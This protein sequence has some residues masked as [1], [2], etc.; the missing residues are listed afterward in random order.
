VGN[1]DEWRRRFHIS[2][3]LSNRKT[4][5][6]IMKKVLIPVLLFAT[7]VIFEHCH[8]SKKAH[9]TIAA[10]ETTYTANVQNI[11]AANCSPCHVGQ[12]ARQKR[13]DS[14][15]AVKSNIDDIIRRV[16]L[17]PNDKGFMPMRHPKLPDSTIQ[18]FVNWK[19]SGLMQ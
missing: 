15:D 7:V 11:V 3:Y 17:N 9:K 4:T 14:Y 13:L 18:V 8:S 1:L 16:Q 6:H 2:S 5:N 10:P 12:G 19:N